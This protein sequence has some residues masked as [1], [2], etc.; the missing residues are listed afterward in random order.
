M[1]L[2]LPRK[3]SPVNA[4]TCKDKG[5]MLFGVRILGEGEEEEEEEGEVMRKCSSMEDLTLFTSSDHGSVDHGYLS[6]G[7]LQPSRKGKIMRK[8]GVPWTEEEHKTFLEGLKK[9]GKGDWRGISRN[10]VKTRTPTQVASHAQKYFLRQTAP[11][12]KK[13]RSSLF[14][15]VIDDSAESSKIPPT[16]PTSPSSPS[17]GSHRVLHEINL[18]NH[19]DHVV[20]NSAS[21]GTQVEIQSLEA[22]P[23]L[24]FI[25]TC[26]QV[27]NFCS[28]SYTE[29]VS[30]GMANQSM[31]QCSGLLPMMSL[32]PVHLSSQAE[33]FPAKIYDN[34]APYGPDLQL[35]FNPTPQC[36]PIALS[37]SM[38]T[39]NLDLTIAP[40][41]PLKVTKYSSGTSDFAAAIQV[42]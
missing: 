2:D 29:E 13:R 38:E 17:T 9:L 3:S 4:K 8:R 10:F 40:P 34:S 24:P 18:F 12:T 36:N 16:S 37:P 1:A 39:S 21:N 15:V 14:D 41:R 30:N 28:S 5:L 33:L 6:D 11:S 22:S 32:N 20:R 27:S 19:N 23:T 31:V 25:T 42:I 35:Y 26:S 7:P